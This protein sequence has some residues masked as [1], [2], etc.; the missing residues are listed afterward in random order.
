MLFIVAFSQ[1]GPLPACRYDDILTART[2]YSE[3]ATTLLD[4][5]YK[6]P[7]SYVP[8]DLV[9]ATKAGLSSGYEVRSLVVPDLTALAQAAEA[10]G[11]PL[12][13]QSAYRSYSYQVKTFASWVAQEGRAQALKVS[14]RPG[15]SEHQLGTVLDFRTAGGKPAWDYDDWA[16][17]P[18]GKWLEAN[19]HRYGF[20]MSYPKDEEALTCYSYEPWHYR[21]VGREEAG[22]VFES[23]LTLRQWLWQKAGGG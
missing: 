16:T 17:T 11:H 5:I 21:Y 20:V 12:A 14:A 1:T 18:T 3:W 10:A 23:G 19:A 7:E 4:T 15:H 13:V 6:L 9:S 22:A 8:P 2:E